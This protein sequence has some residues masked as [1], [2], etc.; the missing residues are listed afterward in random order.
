MNNNIS[1]AS[2]V[3]GAPVHHA[4]THPVDVEVAPALTHSNRLTEAFR[5]LLALPH[6]L[7]VGGPVAFATSMWWRAEHESRFDA[8]AGVGALGAVSC[9]IAIIAW[10]SIFFTVVN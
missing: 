5:P 4:V 2:G 7:L 9:V 3:L 10:V 6:I 1:A 8:G